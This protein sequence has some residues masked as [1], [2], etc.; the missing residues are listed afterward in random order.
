M[1]FVDMIVPGGFGRG[2][3]A[4]AAQFIAIVDLHGRQ[5]GDFAAVRRDDH[6]EKLSPPHTRR[7]LR[8]LFFKL[9]DNLMSSYGRPMFR[10]VRDDVGGA[11]DATVPACDP[12]R[13]SV[14]FGVC[15]HRNC[16]ENL[17]EGLAPLGI[18]ILDVPDPFNFFQ[19]GPVTADGRMQLADPK[20]DPGAMLVLEA[21]MD[22]E[23]ALSPCPQDII[24]GNGLAVTDM[25][26]L[27]TDA[28]PA[29]E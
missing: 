20:S 9:G 16:L 10:V 26:V 23:C 5:A 17:H 12:T 4:A 11:H 19:N 15:G 6:G 8:S 28:P 2:F 27:V 3:S 7:H 29:R 22:V 14:D 13:Y 1:I 18:G 25:R 24:P 21:L